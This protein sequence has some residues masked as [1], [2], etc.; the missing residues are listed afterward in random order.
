MNA[1]SEFN[2]QYEIEN[3]SLISSS[4][5]SGSVD[6]ATLKD[7]DLMELV[8]EENTEAFSILMERHL[9][10]VKGLAARIVYTGGD[11][12]D[13]AQ[14]VFINVWNRK[15][16]WLNWRSAFS[17]WLYRI[18]VHKCIDLNKK[19]RYSSLD[20]AQEP[21]SDALD[22]ISQLHLMQFSHHLN[23]AIANLS[24]GQQKAISLHYN[25]G[26]TAQE[27]AKVLG[28]KKSAVEALLKRARL[29]LREML[30]GSDLLGDRV[31]APNQIKFAM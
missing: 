26:M 30:D 10:R 9:S 7:E 4:W 28:M 11:V 17:T 8:V 18:T 16:T 20:D 29:K 3:S 21:V 27:C 2:T 14:E 12:E 1:L 19:V 23:Q 25:E 22:A 31:D 15:N 13:A 24:E 6:L 5:I